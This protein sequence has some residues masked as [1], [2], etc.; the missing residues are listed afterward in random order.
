VAPTDFI[1]GQTATP[2]STGTAVTV[3][4]TAGQEKI[5]LGG[6]TAGT[7]GAAFFGGNVSLGGLDICT[8]GK[9]TFFDGI[10]AFF[11]F[12]YTGTGDGFTFT[13]ANGTD[14]GLDAYGST[15]GALGYAGVSPTGKQIVKPKMAVEFDTYTNA[16]QNDPDDASWTNRDM[17][18]FDYWGTDAADVWDDVHHDEDSGGRE[19]K[20]EFTSTWGSIYTTPAVDPVDGSIYVGSLDD[21]LWSIRA[22]GTEKWRSN[23]GGD[24]YT[25]PVIGSDRTVYVGSNFGS[26]GGDINA[27]ANTGS[28][29]WYYSVGDDVRTSPAID[30]NDI[31][32]F[33]TYSSD[34]YFYA[35][36]AAS[37]S[38]YK[39]RY[40]LG[41]VDV[42]SDVALSPDETSVYFVAPDPGG[43]TN[44][45]GNTIYYLYALRTANGAFLWR[46]NLGGEGHSSP[47]VAE[48]GT[49]YVGSDGVVNVGYLFAVNPDGTLKWRYDFTPTNP[50]NRPALGADG[51]IYIGN[52]DDYLYAVS[53]DGTSASLKWRF[54]TSGD[55]RG[56][57]LAHDDG[58]IWFGS[59]DNHVYAVDA[60]GHQLAVYDVGADVRAGLSQGPDGTV[61]VAAEDGDVFAFSP[62]CQ[63]QNIK[64][65]HYSYDDLLPADIKHAISSANN[66]LESGP[67]AVRIEMMRSRSLN[68][69]GRYPYT[70]RLW[71]RQ[72]QET[73]CS[74]ILGTYF[75]DTRV[76]YAAKEPHLAQTAELCAA[77]HAKLDTF[78]FGFTE[79]TGSA[80]QTV[81]ISDVQ[82]GFIRPGDFVIGSDPGWP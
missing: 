58:S 31:L 39:W 79:G 11:I 34:N 4:T 30:S 18:Q 70:L 54:L 43:A 69:R 32:Y 36:D 45:D 68:A 72:C 10:R 71:I 49:I 8:G 81:N 1:S 40:N 62:A 63:P 50:R 12:D 80:V 29:R 41:A 74:D 67:W 78:I 13:V 22:D 37:P 25:S 20:W 59:N 77:D 15:G 7:S 35:I 23:M 47:R 21:H 42:K 65:R 9:C 75:E 66:W 82:L 19:Q 61:Y 6:N 64:N 26:P 48:D 57:P 14:N 38:T 24:I 73:D 52:D 17:I 2:E 55:V 5:V 56:S 51:T 3:D 76:E 16:G 44:V 46:Y 28:F 53:D 27:V 60:D 33:G